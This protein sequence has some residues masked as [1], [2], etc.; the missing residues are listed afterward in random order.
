MVAS[1]SPA[2]RGTRPLRQVTQEG[3][4]SVDRID[5]PYPAVLEPLR[6]VLGLLREPAIVRPRCVQRE[7]ERYIEGKVGLAH[8]AAVD[9]PFHDDRLAEIGEGK[10]AR[11]ARGHLKKCVIFFEGRSGL[12]SFGWLDGGHWGGGRFS[13]LFGRVL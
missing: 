12:R 3:V 13:K 9:L 10:L 4:G 5:H 6:I 8:L 2:A 7:F 11:L 1:A